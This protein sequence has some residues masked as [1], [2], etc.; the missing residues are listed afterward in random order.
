MRESHS[1]LC[2]RLMTAEWRLPGLLVRAGHTIESF[3]IVKQLLMWQ[4][5]ECSIVVVH[6]IEKLN[7]RIKNEHSNQAQNGSPVWAI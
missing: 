3:Q 7:Y 4:V 5:A 6:Y 2:Y 1:Q